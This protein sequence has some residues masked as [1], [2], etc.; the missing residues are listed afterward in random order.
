[1][2]SGFGLMLDVG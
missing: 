2:T 1:M